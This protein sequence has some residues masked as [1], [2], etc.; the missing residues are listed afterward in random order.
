MQ[1]L[2]EN[3]FGVV[4]K[5]G[6]DINKAF[7]AYEIL[8]QLFFIGYY[9]YN[10]YRN[11]NLTLFIVNLVLLALCSVYFILYLVALFKKGLYE[12][13]V[14]KIHLYLA[15]FKI[16]VRFFTI[17]LSIYLFVSFGSSSVDLVFLI[18]AVAGLMLQVFFRLFQMAFERYKKMFEVAVE[19]DVED[20][21]GSPVIKTA[22][23]IASPGRTFF[24]ITNAVLTKISHF[25]NGSAPV[26]DAAETEAKEGK[27]K[28]RVGELGAEANKK[29]EANKQIKKDAKK[30]EKAQRYQEE[31][32]KNK[33][34]LADIFKKT[35]KKV[36]PKKDEEAK[37]IT[38]PKE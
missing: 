19:M 20:I 15:G 28:E 24:Q 30:K 1:K 6:S 16:L 37:Q 4:D 35:E 31:K 38:P 36:G 21:K 26:I 27:L 17:G 14:K 22:S 25:V 32:A 8:I 34:L 3:T 11:E 2:F 9:S 13:V 33:A 12:R 29:R 18:V 5:I 10:V 23:A 7:Q